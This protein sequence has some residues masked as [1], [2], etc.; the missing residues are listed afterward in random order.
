MHF[1]IAPCKVNEIRVRTDAVDKGWASVESVIS[2]KRLWAHYQHYSWEH[3]QSAHH[4]HFSKACGR[5]HRGITKFG[6]K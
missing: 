6:F 5:Y 2:L 1:G 4:T 3:Q